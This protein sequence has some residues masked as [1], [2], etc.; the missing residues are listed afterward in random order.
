MVTSWSITTGDGST[1]VSGNVT[2]ATITVPA[3]GSSTN[4]TV[5]FAAFGTAGVEP[6]IDNRTVTQF[7]YK[8]SEIALDINPLIGFVNDPFV[9]TIQHSYDFTWGTTAD[10]EWSMNILQSCCSMHNVLMGFGHTGSSADINDNRQWDNFLCQCWK[11][12]VIC[13]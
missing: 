11:L 9:A 7:V 5:Q 6:L 1:T 2:N 4:T 3:T 10:S 8:I 12:Y 13:C